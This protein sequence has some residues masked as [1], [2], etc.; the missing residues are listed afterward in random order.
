MVVMQEPPVMHILCS[1][2]DLPKKV[3][4]RH[5]NGSESVDAA[6]ASENTSPQLGLLEGD[7][8]HP[9]GPDSSPSGTQSA[10]AG[11]PGKG[12]PV[13]GGLEG[14]GP[15]GVSKTGMKFRQQGKQPGG[16]RR[17]GDKG[18]QVGSSPPRRRPS[19]S[20]TAAE[21]A[22]TGGARQ[23]R[24]PMTTVHIRPVDTVIVAAVPVPNGPSPPEE[25]DEAAEHGLVGD[26][27]SLGENDAPG[28]GQPLV[29]VRSEII[30]DPAHVSEEEEGQ[31]TQ[32]RSWGPRGGMDG[33]L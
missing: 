32:A 15:Q 33:E 27:D 12:L 3:A 18:R 20:R 22:S 23:P 21:T 30:V 11:A 29:E 17:E 7:Q 5:A 16:A 6:V 8:S 28:Q 24:A 25:V 9:Q 31:Q 2:L 14:P 1:P 10:A 26:P 19:H 13:V 4:D